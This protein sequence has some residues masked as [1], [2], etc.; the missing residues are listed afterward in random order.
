MSQAG[1]G[2]ISAAGGQVMGTVIGVIIGQTLSASLQP[3][4]MTLSHKAFEIHPNQLLGASDYVALQ[5]RMAE[6]A[7]KASQDMKRLGFDDEKQKW[8]FTITEQLL[9][10]AELVHRYW[11]D[12]YKDKDKLYN[13]A[14]KIGWGKTAID[15]LMKVMEFIPSASDIITFAVREVYTPE[16]AEAFGQFE[17]VD[18]VIAKA[19]HDIEATGMSPET[20]KK[21]WAAHWQLPSISQGFEMLH[22]RVI[23]LKGEH[24]ELDLEKLLIALDVMPAWRDKLVQIS[25]TPYTRV[26]VRR[27]HKL[28]ILSDD[29]LVDAYMDLGYD[30]TRAKNMAEFTIKYNAEPPAQEQTPVEQTIIKERDLTKSDILNGYRDALLTESEAKSALADLGYDSKEV[31]YYISRIDYNKERDEVDTYLRYYHDAYIRYIMTYDDMVDKLGELNLPASRIEKLLSIWSLERLARTNKP[32]KAEILTF[33]RKKVI[34]VDTARNELR[35]LGY[36]ERYIDWYLK[37]V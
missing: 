27:M 25:Y 4:A 29:E 16:I 33:V 35:G 19:R 23:P 22:R 6:V 24:G 21:Y 13:D 20:F 10:A 28:G 2:A 11:R 8:L 31:D 18:D 9:N 1:V 36:A 12:P 26:D 7:A 15:D 17:G 37:T 3:L 14:A 32:T 34:D 30:E 5:R